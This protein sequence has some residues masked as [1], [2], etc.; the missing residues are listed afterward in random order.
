MK[1]RSRRRHPAPGSRRGRI[2]R[3]V[4]LL[5]GAIAVVF[6]AVTFVIL[7]QRVRAQFGDTQWRLPAHV[8]TRPMELY[9]GRALEQ[10]AVLDHLRAAG[11]RRGELP[12]GEGEYAFRGSRLRIHT[13]PFRYPDGVEPARE[14]GV[15]FDD[16][17]IASVDGAQGAAIARLQPQRIGQVYAGRR[18]DRELVAL[19]DVPEELVQALIAV[20]DRE[21]FDHW[22]IQ[23]SAIGR[24]ALANL[25]AGRTVQGGSTITQQ[26]VKNYFLSGE[27]TLTRKFTEALMSASLEWHFSKEQILEAYLN[28]VYLGQDGGRA[29]RGFGL[30]AQFWFDRPLGEL[31]LHQLALL[32]GMIKG[33]GL[34]DPRANPERARDRRDVVL[35]VLARE[36]EIDDE[37]VARAR[38]QPI[39][40]VDRD[41]V[42]LARY[43]AYLDLVRRELS[44]EYSDQELRTGGLRV[45]THLDPQAQVAAQEAVAQRV[46]RLDGP[47]GELQG[48]AVMAELDSGAVLAIVGDRDAHRSGFNRALDA[49]RQVGSL[50]K[51]A[52]YYSALAHPERYTLATPISDAP[53]EL[54]LPGDRTWAPEN[55][56]EEFHGT[57]PLVDAL[58]QSYNVATARLGME[59][60]LDV[61]RD[62]LQRIDG[63]EREALMPADLLGAL[64]R[65]PL[66]VTGMYQTLGA[67]GFDA[68]L[69]SID[70]VQGPEGDVLTSDRLEVRQALDPTPTFLVNS[71]LEQ[72]AQR[73]TGRGLQWLLPDRRVAGKTGTT[74]EL[75]DSWF[76]GFDGRH[77]GVT[78]VGHDDNT[79]AGLTGSAG[80]LRVWAD[81]MRAVPSAPRLAN[82]PVGVEWARVDLAAGRSVSARC[83]DAPRLPFAQGSVPPS[84]RDC[85]G[86]RHI[87]QRR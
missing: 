54:E 19:D 73:G 66:D 83:A 68:P 27:Q 20:E 55:Y 63:A 11:Y 12:L 44:D 36:T 45:F 9:D 80:A 17:R 86:P 41:A 29:I 84:Q 53:F 38:T 3:R 51:P 76:A 35:R 26:L 40:V 72:V 58:A 7:D 77:V 6:T 85:G 50:V 16:G 48:A 71:A 39:D 64:S 47:E 28:E 4:L 43:P 8:Y 65:T 87:G 59:I 78:W 79:P 42:R 46:T 70:A 14:L 24:A 81:M 30:G 82:A 15:H 32:V 22:G 25:R 69:T 10:Q 56:D 34:Y 67:G 23:P 2:L 37:R 18:T 1:P 33:P 13:R 49:R 61:V 60:G 5:G 57:V 52:V 31:E 75:R 62:T 74:N 21:F